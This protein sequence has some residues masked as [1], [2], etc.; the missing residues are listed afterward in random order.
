MTMAISKAVEE[1]SAGGHL[2]LDRQHLGLGRGLCRPRRHD[3]RRTRPR[4]QDRPRQAGPGPRPRRPAAAGAGQLRRL[5]RPVPRPVG[6]L[7]R[8]P[9]Q[10]RQP[11][12]HRGP[13][14]RRLRDRRRP[15]RRP[16][17]PLPAGR[18]R[19]QHH[20]VLEG[21]H[22]VPAS[23]PRMLGFQAAGAA[24]IVTGKRVEKPSTI[25]TAIRIGNPASW[26][27]A[28]HARDESGGDIQAV[29]DRQI[30]EAYRL[31]AAE[32]GGL[33]RAGLR[34]V[35]RRPAAGPGV[36][37]ARRARASGSCAP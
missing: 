5:P 27:E 28:L 23:G 9:G 21:L 36:R 10:L 34:R 11:V 18:Q 32:G 19:R 2:R 30:L 6:E 22:R 4:R 29:T 31:L 35:R 33:R 20:G 1:G 3:L 26:N 17:R 15:R 7:P 12:P 8:H 14:D 37:R 24:P 13:E 25:A 16:R